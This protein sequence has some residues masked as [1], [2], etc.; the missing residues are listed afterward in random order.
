[1]ETLEDMRL[2]VTSSVAKIERGFTE[3]DDDWIQI[4]FIQTPTEINMLPLHN[5]WFANGTSKDLLGEILKQTVARF[6]T[7]R[8]GILL[9][10]F[11]LAVDAPGGE[12]ADLDA[13]FMERVRSEGVRLSEHPRSRE[14]LML[15]LGDAEGE[16]EWHCYIERHENKPPTLTPWEQKPADAVSTGRFVGLNAYL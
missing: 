7:I 12:M 2:W 9:N 14:T 8:Y 10:C 3:P 4:M 13:N 6:G 11:S 15:I 5:E 16:Q 1:M